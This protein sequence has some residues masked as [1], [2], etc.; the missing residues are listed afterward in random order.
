MK[1]FSF[2]H[3]IFE[4][5]N[6]KVTIAFEKALIFEKV[7]YVYIKYIKSLEKHFLKLKGRFIEAKVI[8]NGEY[9]YYKGYV[10]YWITALSNSVFIYNSDF[11]RYKGT[12][13]Y[14]A[15]K[16]VFGFFIFGKRFDELACIR[17]F[18]D[19]KVRN[20][21]IILRIK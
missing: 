9:F 18:D 14:R 21:K 13:Y 7:G 10:P 15:S 6:F 4:I 3:L 8:K 5:K 20:F 12:I 19:G 17:L 2:L 16:P 11:K 1:T